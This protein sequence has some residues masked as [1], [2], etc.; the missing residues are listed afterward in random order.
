MKETFGLLKP[1]R[2]FCQMQ[3]RVMQCDDAVRDLTFLH[4]TDEL[5]RFAA[6][7]TLTGGGGTDFRPAFAKIEELRRDGTLRDLQACF[8]LPMA[9]APTLPA[10]ALRDSFS[11]FGNRHPAARYPALGPCG[12]V[13]SRKNFCLTRCPTP[14][15]L[16]GRR[17][18]RGPARVVIHLICS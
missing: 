4:S 11:V 18:K 15:K 8:T 13:L 3:H 1:A 7:L 12:M 9:K 14:G 17:T 6:C 5:D 2:A 16:T 10:P